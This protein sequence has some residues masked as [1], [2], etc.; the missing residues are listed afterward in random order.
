MKFPVAF[1]GKL[2]F[3][4]D[5]ITEQ[6]LLTEVLRSLLV[7]L[8]LGKSKK[9]LQSFSIRNN[10][11]RFTVAPIYSRIFNPS[12]GPISFFS[13]P[14]RFR[15][16]ILAIGPLSH[17]Q[18]QIEHNDNSLS[19]HYTLNF[20]EIFRQALFIFTATALFGL[21]AL[22][23]EQRF[24]VIFVGFCVIAFMIFGLYYG[25]NVLSNM[26]VFRYYLKKR[27]AEIIAG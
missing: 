5:S 13:N 6:P 14:K 23:W 2:N 12:L 10:T 25:V 3:H 20:S 7:D 4:S 1:T 18:L 22:E 8:E 27:V 17:A 15:Q 19:I 21:T 9:V 26:V 16:F 11:V 24:S